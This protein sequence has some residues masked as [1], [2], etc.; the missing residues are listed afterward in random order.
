MKKR[1]AYHRDKLR[2]LGLAGSAAYLG[3]RVIA[4][5][6][7]F[8]ERAEEWA[9][10]ILPGLF[11][12]ARVAIRRA[13]AAYDPPDCDGALELFCVEE[14]RAEAY[15][16]P[17]MGW[18]GNANGGIRVHSLPGSHM[19][20]LSEPAVQILANQLRE[21]LAE[22]ANSGDAEPFVLGAGKG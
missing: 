3:P 6:H 4:F 20:M 2:T 5:G 11:R 18:D 8:R 22:P 17:G 19:A 15:D 1:L 10:R 16:Y 9:D 21:S 14:P 12:N 13:A 7:G